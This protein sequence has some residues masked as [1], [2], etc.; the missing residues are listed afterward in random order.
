MVFSH[1]F[2]RGFG[3]FSF[4]FWQSLKTV[5]IKLAHVT[6]IKGFDMNSLVSRKKKSI[7]KVRRPFRLWPLMSYPF[8]ENRDMKVAKKHPE[9]H[10]F[11]RL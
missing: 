7:D 4:F 5:P 8:Q 9:I 3:E 6:L 1:F 2:K 10:V 11:C